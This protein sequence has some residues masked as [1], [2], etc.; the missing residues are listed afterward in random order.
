M[1]QFDVPGNIQRLPGALLGNPAGEPNNFVQETEAQTVAWPVETGA[2]STVGLGTIPSGDAELPQAVHWFIKQ[3][4]LGNGKAEPTGAAKPDGREQT[5][6]QLAFGKTAGLPADAKALSGLVQL[7]GGETAKLTL[8]EAAQAGPVTQYAVMLE[9]PGEPGAVL[10]ATLSV[11]R[12]PA[13]VMLNSID[14]PSPHAM[15]RGSAAETAFQVFDLGA[16]AIAGQEAPSPVVET[17]PTQQTHVQPAEPE[18][19]QQASAAQLEPARQAVKAAA[20]LPPESELLREGVVKTTSPV[21]VSKQTSPVT[22]EQAAD[23]LAA[24]MEMSSA[25]EAATT[26]LVDHTLKLDA[27]PAPASFA[28]EFTPLQ[29]LAKQSQVTSIPLSLHVDG[30]GMEANGQLFATNANLPLPMSMLQFTQ[31]ET[32]VSQFTSLNYLDLAQRVMDE[33]AQARQS[34]DGV[35]TAK[36]NLN[37]PNL[38]QLSVNIAVHG[39]T[40]ALQLAVASSAPK[41]KLDDSLA[42]LKQSLE[43]AGLEVVEL[44]VVQTSNQGEGEHTGE[45]QPQQRQSEKRHAAHKQA[46]FMAAP[47]TGRAAQAVPAVS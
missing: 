41:S 11:E 20:I 30:L 27:Q 8:V 21:G 18:L 13:P 7:A 6:A 38:G 25:K 29:R 23:K 16:R 35:Y 15:Q 42:Q 26:K 10:T 1:C 14:S 39:E 34:G 3:G 44:R 46:T 19:K 37:P 33:A 47:F 17:V 43:D 9:A 4:L 12:A 36:L 5:A 22:L 45:D 28:A 31:P 24:V 2:A 32:P 40:V